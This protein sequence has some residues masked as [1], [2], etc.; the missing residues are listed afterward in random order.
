MQVTR[1]FKTLIYKAVSYDCSLRHSRQ[2]QHI[3]QIT[4]Q[5]TFHKEKSVTKLAVKLWR[6]HTLAVLYWFSHHRNWIEID[7]KKRRLR[8]LT[9][10]QPQRI[11]MRFLR[12][13]IILKPNYVCAAY[14]RMC[15]FKT[16]II[17]FVSPDKHNYASK[18]RLH[19][20]TTCY[21]SKCYAPDIIQSE[22]H[23]N[24]TPQCNSCGHNAREYVGQN[25]RAFNSFNGK[26]RLLELFCNT[27]QR[28]QQYYMK[29]LPTENFPQPVQKFNIPQISL[30]CMANWPCC[31]TPPIQ[32]S[33]TCNFLPSSHTQTTSHKSTAIHGRAHKHSGK[34][35]GHTLHV[36]SK[37]FQTL[38]HNSEPA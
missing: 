8:I 16:N 1:V 28:Q 27:F 38:S 35:N 9:R 14:R 29:N 21:L 34:P 5:M 6:M 36:V 3:V 30:P 10:D 37:N 2:S 32:Y 18:E 20:L 25:I 4:T 26:L 19:T 23:R 11:P 31:W 17:Y 7:Y 15:S 22:R 24:G 33:C 13:K 12:Q